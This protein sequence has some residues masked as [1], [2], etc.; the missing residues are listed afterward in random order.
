M[1]SAC[2]NP[3]SIENAAPEFTHVIWETM[4]AISR[5]LGSEIRIWH[6]LDLVSWRAEVIMDYSHD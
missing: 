2:T 1:R 6:L 3:W 4:D 5:N